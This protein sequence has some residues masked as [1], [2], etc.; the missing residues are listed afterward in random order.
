ME[1]R[2]AIIPS[3]IIVAIAGI[4]LLIL[5]LT[6]F[7]SN[8]E[9]TFTPKKNRD[10]QIASVKPLMWSCLREEEDEAN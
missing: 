8:R 1:L 10:C 9:Y 5:I 3:A 4:F 6:G 7:N 2:D